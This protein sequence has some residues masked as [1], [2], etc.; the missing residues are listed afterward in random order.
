[1]FELTT[2]EVDILKCQSGISSYSHGGRRRIVGCGSGLRS[3]HHVKH[4]V[5]GTSG[6][7]GPESARRFH[8]GKAV[9]LNRRQQRQRRRKEL[10]MSAANLTLKVKATGKTRAVT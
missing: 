1:M 6:A 10:R 2:E 5:C 4:R 7:V 3:Q 9:G 8:R